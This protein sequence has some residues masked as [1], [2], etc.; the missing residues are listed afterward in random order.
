[1]RKTLYFNNILIL[2]R[3]P[4]HKERNSKLHLNN[5]LDIG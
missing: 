3:L 5:H 4:L 2:Y 1:M